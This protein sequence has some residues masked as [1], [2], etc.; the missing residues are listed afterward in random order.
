M[1][2]QIEYASG[3]GGPLGREENLMRKTANHPLLRAK[4]LRSFGRDEEAEKLER[5][6]MTPEDFAAHQAELTGAQ[7]ASEDDAT[8]E[9]IKQLLQTV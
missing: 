8:R 2:R 4:V 6:H 7:D 1:I 5:R 3:H 9:R